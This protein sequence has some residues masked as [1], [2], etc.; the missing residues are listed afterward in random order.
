MLFFHK[1]LKKEIPNVFFFNTFYVTS[2]FN[3]QSKVKG[4]AIA[5]KSLQIAEFMCCHA[6][7]LDGMYEYLDKT[8]NQPL[9]I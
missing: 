3:V 2:I 7:T 8:H 6:A 9:Y 5:R 4:K 1:F